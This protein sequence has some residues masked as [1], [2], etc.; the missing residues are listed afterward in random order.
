ME[1]TCGELISY[2][3]RFAPEEAVGIFITNPDK[4]IVHKIDK[5]FVMEGE[6]VMLIE[7]TWTESM[8][9]PG[10]GDVE[11]EASECKPTT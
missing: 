1:L 11:T 5:A 9:T 3:S 4:R 6:S 2:L 10:A 7:T 8:N